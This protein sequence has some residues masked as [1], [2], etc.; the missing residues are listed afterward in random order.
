MV[1][2]DG[3]YMSIANG[4]PAVIRP[5]TS[6]V[7]KKLGTGSTPGFLRR[8][9]DLSGTRPGLRSGFGRARGGETPPSRIRA[10]SRGGRFLA[11]RPGERLDEGAGPLFAELR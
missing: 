2:R 3:R 5:R 10:T 7:L 6:A 1:G 4:P 9:L 11:E 8:V